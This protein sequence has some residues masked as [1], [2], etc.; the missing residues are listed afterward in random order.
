MLY[1]LPINYIVWKHINLCPKIFESLDKHLWEIKVKK[2]GRARS[3]C[4]YI[5][6]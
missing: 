4:L 2:F 1:L 6:T 5:N 3:K